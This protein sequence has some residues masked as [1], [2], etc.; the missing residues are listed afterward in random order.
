MSSVRDKLV[1]IKSTFP[2]TRFCSWM[3]FRQENQEEYDEEEE[4]GGKQ[5]ESEISVRKVHVKIKRKSPSELVS[6]CVIV[7]TD[8]GSGECSGKDELDRA[9]CPATIAGSRW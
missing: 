1:L 4:E 6:R 7:M 5:R 2:E 3:Q 8:G 9:V